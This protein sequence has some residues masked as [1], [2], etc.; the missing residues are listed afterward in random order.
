MSNSFR[1]QL[2]IISGLESLSEGDQ[3]CLGLHQ[4]SLLIMGRN[5]LK[6][7]TVTALC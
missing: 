3:P 5:S 6:Y 2:G 7:D 1:R 4:S